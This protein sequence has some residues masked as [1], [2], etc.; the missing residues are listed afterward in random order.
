VQDEREPAPAAGGCGIDG[1]ACGT[2]SGAC[3][4][5]CG[6]LLP[7]DLAAA[8]RAG[9]SSCCCRC[10]QV[11]HWWW[12][13]PAVAWQRCLLAADDKAVLLLLP[14]LLPIAAV[15]SIIPVPRCISVIT[16]GVVGSGSSRGGRAGEATAEA[17]ST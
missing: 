3:R 16:L 14:L 15:A 4:S 10:H 11:W 12:Q 1:S 17:A 6:R 7:A 13:V 2:T 5:I 8:L 9:D